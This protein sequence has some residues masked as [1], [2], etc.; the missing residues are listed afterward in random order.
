VAG[1]RRRNTAVYLYTIRIPEALCAKSGFEE[2][3]V[4][5]FSKKEKS[6]AS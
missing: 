4:E 2:K 5:S 6:V 1:K 3:S